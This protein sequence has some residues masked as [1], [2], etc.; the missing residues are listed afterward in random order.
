MGRRVEPADPVTDAR[1]IAEWIM[2]QI[3]ERGRNRTYQ[4]RLVPQIRELFGEEWLYKNHNNNWAIDR[5][6]LKEF[7]P[8]KTR[9]VLWERG[10][11]SWRIVEDDE[12]ERIH[13]RDA[14]RKQRRE[15]ALE[16]RA[17]RDAAHSP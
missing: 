4:R 3:V 16:A 9:N 6:V 15:D 2:A 7:G 17:E 10:D 1:E 11:Q 8:L 5:R 12:L 14:L 13:E